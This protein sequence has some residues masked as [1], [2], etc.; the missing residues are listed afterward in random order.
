MIGERQ[1]IEPIENCKGGIIRYPRQMKKQAVEQLSK[2]INEWVDS[3]MKGF[4]LLPNNV[5]FVPFIQTDQ[6]DA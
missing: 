4:I 2:M 1:K 3:G 6:E 5:E